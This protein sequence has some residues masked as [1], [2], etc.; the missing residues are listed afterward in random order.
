MKYLYWGY[1]EK[2]FKP[3]NELYDLKTDPLELTNQFSSSDYTKARKKM[4]KLYD[5]H[6]AHWKESA[7][8][9][10]NYQKFGT[11]FDRKLKW[12]E[13]VRRVKNLSSK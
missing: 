8:A 9:Y 5:Q 2:G 7:V 10:N 3:A 6:L 12:D 11:L 13:K 4:Q 1:A